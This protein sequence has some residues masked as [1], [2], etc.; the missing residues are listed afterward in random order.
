LPKDVKTEPK[1]VRGG[2]WNQLGSNCRYEGRMR[3]KITK[4][5]R[6]VRKE[7]IKRKL[8]KSDQKGPAR[9]DKQ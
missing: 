3:Y 7:E 5:K 1:P 4:R 9:R 2:R 8:K 6:G